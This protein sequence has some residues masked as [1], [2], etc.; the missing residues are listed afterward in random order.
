MQETT[1]HC[2]KQQPF[3]VYHTK[4]R[5]RCSHGDHLGIS[6]NKRNHPSTNGII[7]QNDYCSCGMKEFILLSSKDSVIL[8]SIS[9]SPISISFI[10]S[11]VAI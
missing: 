1:S 6:T 7:L 9:V 11:G 2:N 10:A 5:A 8:I 4:P 3:D